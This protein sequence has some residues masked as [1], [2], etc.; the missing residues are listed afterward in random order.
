MREQHVQNQGS[1]MEDGSFGK[2]ANARCRT[3]GKGQKSHL[4]QKGM[5]LCTKLESGVSQWGGV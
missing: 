5:D 2:L 4:A 1:L 3:V